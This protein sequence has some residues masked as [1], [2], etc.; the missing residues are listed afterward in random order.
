MSYTLS[1]ISLNEFIVSD[2]EEIS[3]DEENNENKPPHT[4]FYAESPVTPNYHR[5]HLKSPNVS[6]GV[7]STPGNNLYS[8]VF[9]KSSFYFIS[10]S[11]QV[12]HIGTELID[13]TIC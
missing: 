7:C 8:S 5:K 1:Y 12:T 9:I 6:P 13:Y 2:S 10:I 3:E 4:L 11:T